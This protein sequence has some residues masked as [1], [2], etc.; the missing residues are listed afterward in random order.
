MVKQKKVIKK[1]VKILVEDRSAYNCPD[2]NGEGLKDQYHVCEK[3]Q[4]TGKI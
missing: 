4:G 1:E 2:C 3:C